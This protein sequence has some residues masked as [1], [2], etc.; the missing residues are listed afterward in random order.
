MDAG[1]RYLGGPDAGPS[2]QAQTQVD[3]DRNRADT[4]ELHS[5]PARRSSGPEGEEEAS[6]MEPEPQATVVKRERARTP[7]DEVKAK[8]MQLPIKKQRRS[9]LKILTQG[10][11]VAIDR[12]TGHRRLHCF[13]GCCRVPH[14]D[15]TYTVFSFVG[16]RLPSVSTCDL[17][18]RRCWSA[19]A[20][21]AGPET[22]DSDGTSEA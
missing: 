4:S 6:V 17:Y 16:K 3:P 18:C 19:S 7:T 21:T 9:F 8:I 1:S 12:N 22:S 2:R 20:P 14:V 5:T 13:G 11:Y 15:Y 10:H